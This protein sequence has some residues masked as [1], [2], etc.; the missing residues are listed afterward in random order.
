MPTG[1]YAVGDDFTLQID[2]SMVNLSFIAKGSLTFGG[3]NEYGVF[4][5]DVVFTGALPLVAISC[6]PANN[7]VV[8]IIR[9]TRVGSTWTVRF[10]ARGDGAATYQATWYLFDH[11]TPPG[12]SGGGLEAYRADGTLFYSSAF[13]LVPLIANAFGTYPA[14]AYAISAMGYM[15]LEQSM[16]TYSAG[17]GREVNQYNWEMHWIGARFTATNTIVEQ[18]L[19]IDAGAKYI[20]SDG[21]EGGSW[22]PGYPSAFQTGFYG[23]PAVARVGGL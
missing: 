16:E 13:K 14:G 18:D 12:G 11:P 10:G 20:V 2:E 17:D 4:Y 23:P 1:F 6:P 21:S 3:G 8:G 19:L 22:W 9:T 5:Q 7:L 15:Q